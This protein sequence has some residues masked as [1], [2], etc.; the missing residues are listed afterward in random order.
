M[1]LQRHFV[2]NWN[3]Q[4][5]LNNLLTTFVI[6]QYRQTILW[7]NCRPIWHTNI[8]SSDISKV[9]TYRTHIGRQPDNTK[10]CLCTV[11]TITYWQRTMNCTGLESAQQQKWKFTQM[12]KSPVGR[13]ITTQQPITTHVMYYV[14][15]AIATT[16]ATIQCMSWMIMLNGQTVQLTK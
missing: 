13:D 2:E 4:L 10:S 8:I 12:F 6:Q 16:S 1:K 3:A 15:I 14:I 7:H 5:S 11:L 9:Q